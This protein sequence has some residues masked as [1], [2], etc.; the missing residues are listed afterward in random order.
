MLFVGVLSVLIFWKPVDSLLKR[1]VRFAG[2][3]GE[4]ESYNR[5]RTLVDSLIYEKELIPAANLLV[6]SLGE[7]LHLDTSALF[8]K[9]IN[10]LPENKH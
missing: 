3:K 2:F 4:P 9:R 8:L 1:G 10:G 5:M 7:E 6:N